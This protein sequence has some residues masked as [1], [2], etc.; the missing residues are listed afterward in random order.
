MMLLENVIISCMKR[1]INIFFYFLL[2]C[3]LSSYAFCNVK[4]V[5]S[6]EFVEYKNFVFDQNKICQYK[7]S[8]FYIVNGKSIYEKGP[9]YI[10][11]V[12]ST[13]ISYKIKG[14]LVNKKYFVIYGLNNITV[15]DR[16]K[17]LLLW[18]KEF[19]DRVMLRPLIYLHSLYVSL[20][21]DKILC[22]DLFSGNLNWQY[23]NNVTNLHAYIY[24]KLIQSDTYLFYITSD[25]MH[26][27]N[28]FTGAF[29]DRVSIKPRHV[30]LNLLKESKINHIEL[31]NKIL[32]IC[33]DNGILL[34]FD[35]EYR[36][37]V[38]QK[39]FFNFIN[40]TIY[41]RH[42][43]ALRN[44]GII[45]LIDKSDGKIIFKYKLV[46][47]KN[48]KKL[49]FF[50]KYRKLVVLGHN[51]IYIFNFSF[52]KLELYRNFNIK[53]DNI[54]KSSNKSFLLV[55]KNKVLKE[56]FFLK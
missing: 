14:L 13:N 1:I 5:E 6:V 7:G 22:M 52:I 42:I 46:V 12:L 3:C 17:S 25:K 37:F 20:D 49:A 48:L 54:F 32:Y 41:K 19:E 45:Y 47:E 21:Y 9:G 33:Y 2:V 40:F 44:D 26:I 15:I 56:L 28:K 29:I 51:N 11:K 18:S 31:Y 36:F 53:T 43:L 16:K 23:K 8:K 34:A 55:S 24:I 50:D 27:I 38:W 39:T 35:T 4:S 10:E 30:N